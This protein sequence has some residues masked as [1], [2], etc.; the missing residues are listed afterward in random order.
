MADIADLLSG[1]ATT[2][3]AC[4]VFRAAGWNTTMAGKR[5]TVNDRVF[6]RLISGSKMSESPCAGWLVYGIGGQDR[7]VVSAQ[8]SAPSPMA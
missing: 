8:G 4:E 1:V 7:R 2:G 3:R 6:V 5:I